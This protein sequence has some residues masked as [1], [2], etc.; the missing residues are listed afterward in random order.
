[1]ECFLSRQYLSRKINWSFQLWQGCF[2]YSCPDH[3]YVSRHGHRCRHGGRTSDLDP[4]FARTACEPPLSQ[5][6]SLSCVDNSVPDEVR[7][8]WPR[9]APRCYVLNSP[10][11]VP[12]TTLSPFG[13]ENVD[14]FRPN[15]S[16]QTFK[17][18]HT[19]SSTGEAIRSHRDDEVWEARRHY[20]QR[21]TTIAISRF[22][23]QRIKKGSFFV[24]AQ[25]LPKTRTALFH[26]H[27]VSAF[28]P[29]F[30]IET[31]RSRRQGENERSH[32]AVG[33]LHFVDDGTGTKCRMTG[34]RQFF[35]EGEHSRVKHAWLIRGSQED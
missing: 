24:I 22:N 26:G 32:V 23:A 27:A 10:C 25:H 15:G 19:N 3:L 16:E 9:R 31:Y 17:V 29:A 13:V 11:V 14:K 4:Q 7:A 34:K 35:L 2:Y 18:S 5:D 33:S 6:K 21:K 8:R 30:G 12:R 20:F 1:M 28:P